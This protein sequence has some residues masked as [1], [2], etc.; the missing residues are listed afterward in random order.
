MKQRMRVFA[1][2]N[3]SGKT[4]LVNQLIREG[5]KLINPNTHINPD[6]LNLINVLD[7]D[8]FGLKVDENDFRNFGLNHHFTRHS[9]LISKILELMTTVLMSLKIFHIWVQCYL[10]I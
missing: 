5:N 3:G 6:D 2:P 4:A 10:I 1:G 7:F 9:T 8:K